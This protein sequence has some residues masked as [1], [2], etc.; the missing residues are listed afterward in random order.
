MNMSDSN[1]KVNF[2]NSTLF[3]PCVF[4][5]EFGAMTHSLMEQRWNKAQ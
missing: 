2:V 1:L 5:D 3:L 4:A